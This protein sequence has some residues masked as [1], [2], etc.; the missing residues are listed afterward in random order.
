[1]TTMLYTI[2]YTYVMAEEYSTQFHDVSNALYNETQEKTQF[3][4]DAEH[5]NFLS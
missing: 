1:M 4:L 5:R 3:L 2:D